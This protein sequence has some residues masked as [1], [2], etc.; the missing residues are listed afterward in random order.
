MNFK[1]FLTAIILG[2]AFLASPNAAKASEKNQTELTAF[3]LPG[4]G[5]KAISKARK[6][7]QKKKAKMA[8]KKSKKASISTYT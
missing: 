6:R 3:A 4:K 1:I 5:C 8:R 7:N 2:L